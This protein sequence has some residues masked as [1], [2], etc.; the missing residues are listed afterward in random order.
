MAILS[1]VLSKQSDEEL[2]LRL[3]V[4]LDGVKIAK[5]GLLEYPDNDKFK[6]LIPFMVEEGNKIMKE[7]KKRGHE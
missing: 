3:G 1:E 2:I 7:L 4:C 5:R 6:K